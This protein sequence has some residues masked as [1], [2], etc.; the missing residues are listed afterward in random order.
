MS[1]HLF[2][3][4]SG[5]AMNIPLAARPSTCS[6]TA[7]FIN[8]WK[9][10]SAFCMMCPL[11]S[12]TKFSWLHRKGIE[13]VLMFK[14]SLQYFCLIRSKPRELYEYILIVFSLSYSF[15][16]S[17][18]FAFSFSFLLLFSLFLLYIVFSTFFLILAFFPSSV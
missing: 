2:L 13:S 16:F 10:C 5:T 17:F 3:N 6:F 12:K 8:A 1:L 14:I 7:G 9:P 18:S 15:S 11:F 4:C